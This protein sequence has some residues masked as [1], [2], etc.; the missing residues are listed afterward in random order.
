MTPTALLHRLRPLNGPQRLFVGLMALWLAGGAAAALG[1]AAW[2]APAAL[3]TGLLLAFVEWRLLYYVL[4]F[5][6][7]F[8]QEINLPGGLSMDVPSEPLLLALTA[9]VGG[10]LLLGQQRLPRRELRHPLL[11][12]LALLLLWSA[13]DVAFSVN[14]TKSVKYVLAKVWYLVPFMLGTLLVVR[15]PADAW[16]LLGT[17]AAGTALSTVYVMGR[18]AT[19]GL[20]F[21]AINWAARPFYHNHVIYATVLALLV[22]FVLL[23]ARAAPP[24]PRR[25][26][27]HGGLTLLLLGLLSAYTRA[28]LL[29]LPVAGA[30][31]YLV[32]RQ[33]L[34]GP[35]L[36]AL[37]LGAAGTVGYLVSRDNFMRYTPNYEQ[38]VFN[39]H[40]FSKHLQATYQLHDV[41]GIERL[42]RWV[43]AARMVAAKPLV[44]SGP[45]TFYPEYKRYTVRGFRTYVS[46]N[47]EK[48]T[49][50]NYFLLVL[51]EQGV[52]GF[53]L[54]VGLV[55]TALLGAQRLYHRARAQPDVQRVVLAATLSLV[56]IIFH[57]TLNELIEVD[58]IGSVFYICLALLVRADSWLAE[59]GA[60]PG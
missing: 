50:H 45:A 43:A 8:S 7:P 10:A 58:K 60:G 32:L 31:Y 37:A 55:T 38:T 40:S 41:S 18:H 39:P 17:Y 52:P 13:A 46:N 30:Y 25:W 57:L 27:W 36:L 23:G 6:L 12:L 21:D 2:L 28:S 11:V 29:A 33:R 26:L 16:R 53:A 1:G 44:G 48:S 4:L 59:E 14:T 9:C 54:F 5:T 3:G 47:P 34:T 20:A 24:G 51:A 22:P 19:H 15:R 42:Y 49:T 35:L 56:I